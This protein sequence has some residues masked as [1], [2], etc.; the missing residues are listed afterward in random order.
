LQNKNE[1]QTKGF[2]QLRH[3]VEAIIGCACPGVGFGGQNLQGS[4]SKLRLF[5]YKFS[6]G[7]G[8]TIFKCRHIAKAVSVSG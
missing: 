4:S 7:C 2:V 6:S 5:S 3:D 1:R 8:L